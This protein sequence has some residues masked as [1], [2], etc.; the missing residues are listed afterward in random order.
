METNTDALL[1]SSTEFSLKGTLIKLAILHFFNLSLLPKLLKRSIIRDI[2]CVSVG[3]K[4]MLM[5]QETYKCTEFSLRSLQLEN[6]ERFKSEKELVGIFD[7]S[8]R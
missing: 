2:V 7:V 3:H 6:T 1:S 5:L 4:I 8:T